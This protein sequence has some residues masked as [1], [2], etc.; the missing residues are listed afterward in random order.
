MQSEKEKLINMINDMGK[1]EALNMIMT[2]KLLH[3]P[4]WECDGELFSEFECF[5]LIEIGD[6]SGITVNGLKKIWGRTQG[7]ASQRLSIFEEKGL[8][9]KEKEEKDKRHTR[10]CLT[11]KGKK[12][13]KAI[14][15]LK[16]KHAKDVLDVLL[17]HG[18]SLEEIEKC[19]EINQVMSEYQDDC[20]KR[21]WEL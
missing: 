20:K 11:E 4:K 21:I 16:A 14:K 13:Y 10:I 15:A 2:G 7:A 18:F 6:A 8:I 5:F 3:I 9:Y 19:F 1:Q 17:K 12:I